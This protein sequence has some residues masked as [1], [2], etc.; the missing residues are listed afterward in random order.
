[1]E[2]G[3]GADV[4]W[5][6]NVLRKESLY[7]AEQEEDEINFISGKW[8]YDELRVWVRGIAICL[9]NE[10]F[11]YHFFPFPAAMAASSY[12]LI[13]LYTNFYPSIDILLNRMACLECIQAKMNFFHLYM[14]KSVGW[15][16]YIKIN[17]RWIRRGISWSKR[18]TRRRRKN[19]RKKRIFYFYYFRASISL[20]MVAEPRQPHHTTISSLDT[21][22]IHSF[23]TPPSSTLTH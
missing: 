21:R 18:R 8:N 12:Y 13:T 15:N 23:A 6:A 4:R 3:M 16:I 17:T 5:W 1:M 11:R 22:H 20:V 7:E 19:S 10:W 14:K 2:L 9:P